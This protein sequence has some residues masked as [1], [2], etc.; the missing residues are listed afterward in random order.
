MKRMLFVGLVVPAV[1]SS[2]GGS[3]HK[4]VLPPAPPMHPLI[5]QH[6]GGNPDAFY[7]PDPAHLKVG[8]TITWTNKDHEPHDVTSFAGGFSSGPF[9]FG[10]SY[11]WTAVR[12]GT[13]HYFCTLHPDMHG[14]LVIRP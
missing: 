14:L 9:A 12:P 7:D 8:Q 6:P 13:F 3:G 11:R 10:T 5:V 1:L 4:N 2:C